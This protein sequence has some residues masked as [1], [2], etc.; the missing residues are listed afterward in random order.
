MPQ[1]DIALALYNGAKYL[2]D[3]LESLHRQTF[4]DW[5]LVV[6]DDG[7]TDH[8]LELIKNWAKTYG[9]TVRIVEDQLGNLRVIGN[10]SACFEQTEALYV[11]P[12]DQDDFWFPDKISNAVAEMKVLE[13]QHGA[14]IPLASYCD[15]K[16]VDAQLRE[17]HPSMLEMQGQGRRRLPTL[18]QALAQNVAPG[19]AMIINRPLLSAALPIPKQVAMHDWWLVLVALTMGQLSHIRTPGVAYRQHGSN[20]IGAQSGG[21]ETLMKRARGGRTEYLAWLHRSQMQALALSRRLPPNHRDQNVLQLYGRLPNLH[22]L[23]RRWTAWRHGFSKVGV[24]RNLAFYL[25][26]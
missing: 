23:V 24:V 16:V 10:F 21:W 3:F 2:P 14:S 9:H 13:K 22:P 8:S 12:A 18:A 11:M 5:R 19:C 17:L 26:M 25:L 7:S 20:Q 6:R 1:V 15:L 4:T